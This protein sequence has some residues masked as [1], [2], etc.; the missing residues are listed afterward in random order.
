MPQKPQ[1]RAKDK[2]RLTRRLEKWRAKQEQASAAT[3]PPPSGAPAVRDRWGA[4]PARREGGARR[5]ARLRGGDDLPL[6][7][8]DPHPDVR[9]HDRAE[10]RAEVDERRAPRRRRE[11]LAEAEDDPDHEHEREDRAD[12][13]LLLERLPE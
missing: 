12:L 7:R 13:L 4:P 3:P 5:G 9:G 1:V 2:R 11:Q 6:S 10:H 8:P